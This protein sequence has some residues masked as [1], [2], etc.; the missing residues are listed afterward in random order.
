MR[1]MPQGDDGGDCSILYNL[2][3]KEAKYTSL[4]IATTVTEEAS[5]DRVEMVRRRYIQLTRQLY[6]DQ[7]DHSILR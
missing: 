5:K 4:C 2:S 6:T 7:P 3:G 1:G